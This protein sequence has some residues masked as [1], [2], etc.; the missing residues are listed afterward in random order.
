MSGRAGFVAG[1][2][3]ETGEQLNASNQVFATG[4]SPTYLR[5]FA[6]ESTGFRPG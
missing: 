2:I 3:R 5:P 4:A 6:A 1:E